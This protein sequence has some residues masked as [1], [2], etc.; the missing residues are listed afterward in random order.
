MI[1]VTCDT[2]IVDKLLQTQGISYIDVSHMQ[3]GLREPEKHDKLVG[4][5]TWPWQVS[6]YQQS[7][8]EYSIQS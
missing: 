2:C 6:V 5:S 3:D 1:E 7:I 8:A 4:R